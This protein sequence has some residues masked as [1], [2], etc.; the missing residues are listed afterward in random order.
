[1]KHINPKKKKK[2]ENEINYVTP[3]EPWGNAE[4]HCVIK[5]V[6]YFMYHSGA[7]L[8]DSHADTSITTEGNSVGQTYSNS[9]ETGMS[10]GH[11]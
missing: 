11:F 5:V 7:Q 9:S 10:H 2:K 3:Y 4:Q 6:F 8:I 1:M